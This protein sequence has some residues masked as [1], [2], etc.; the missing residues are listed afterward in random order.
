M[1]RHELLKDVAGKK[2]FEDHR[3]KLI[4]VLQ[5]M[6]TQRADI[7]EIVAYVRRYVWSGREDKD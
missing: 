5:E 3:S 4:R 7:D 6:E 2:V 1:E